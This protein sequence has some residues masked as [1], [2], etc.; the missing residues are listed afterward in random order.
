MSR[1]LLLHAHSPQQQTHAM[2]PPYSDTVSPVAAARSVVDDDDNHICPVCDGECTCAKP[3]PSKEPPPPTP[4]LP[5]LKIKLT[6][7]P[8]MFAKQRVAKQ[9]EQTMSV[10]GAAGGSSFPKRRGRP[11]KALVAARQLALKAGATTPFYPRPNSKKKLKGKNTLVK[12]APLPKRKR[13]VAESSDSSS[14]GLSDID[15]YHNGTASLPTFVPASVLSSTDS[16]AASSSGFDS[17]SS[18]DAE[19]QTFIQE[20]EKSRVRRELLGNEDPSRRNL[21]EDW[22]IHPR[23]RSVGPS[24]AEMEVDSD[25]TEDEEQDQDEQEADDDDDDEADGL[26]VGSGYIGLATGWSEDE[27]SNFD[28]DLFF[29]NLSDTD[30]D[31]EDSNNEHSGPPDVHDE[32]AEDGDQSDLD[33]SDVAANELVLHH[34][35]DGQ[36][37]FSTNGRGLLDVDF[38]VAASVVPSSASP[39]QA[40]D[41]DVDLTEEDGDVEGD[42]T[43]EELVGQDHLPNERAMRMFVLPFSVSSINPLSTMSPTNSPALRHRRPFG[44]QGNTDAPKPADILSGRVF[45]DD[46]DNPDDYDEDV[47]ARS[48]SSKGNGPRTGAFIPTDTTTAIIDDNHSDVPSPHPHSRRR[49]RKFV[50]HGRL[51]PK[52]VPSR[53]LSL[54]LLPPFQLLSS[55]ELTTSPELAAQTMDLDDV[56]D[57][58]YLDSEPSD[59]LLSEELPASP[60]ESRKHLNLSG[61]GWGSDTPTADY[62]KVLKSSPLSTLW[63]DNA[64]KSSANRA[65]DG[66]RTPTNNHPPPPAKTRKQPRKPKQKNQMG[67]E[68]PLHQQHYFRQHHPNQKN[69]SSSQRNNFN[70]SPP[71]SI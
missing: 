60:T 63:Q 10:F 27:E 45:L 28:A 61:W 38:E 31:D 54:P 62:G 9:P 53:Q 19:E 58:A 1:H 43:D 11:P 15:A 29:A 41:Q 16:D 70:G 2:P 69:R 3:P 35:W 65:R 21:H 20:A 68:R 64:S 30:D 22:V 26:R 17:D 23:R 8:S 67:Y 49:R 32:R 13:V 7:P 46:S 6:I 5:S 24:D 18:M 50:S 47:S 51:G 12:R 4:K 37:V 40:T 33:S 57:L 14:S 34:D 56:L 71:A 39:S 55:S 36:L 66:D 59:E 48:V 52:T 42:T 25:A 44:S